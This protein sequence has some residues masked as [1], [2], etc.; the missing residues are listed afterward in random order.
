MSDI[1]PGREEQAA[2]EPNEEDR[3]LVFDDTSRGFGS[4]P[5]RR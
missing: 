4:D 1:V 3:P 5:G 2:P